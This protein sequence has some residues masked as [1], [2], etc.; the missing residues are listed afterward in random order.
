[1]EGQRDRIKKAIKFFREFD[2]KSD[3]EIYRKSVLKFCDIIEAEL[4][5]KDTK[6]GWGA[7]QEVFKDVA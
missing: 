7:G 6:D 2:N 4:N 5:L 1:M 3:R